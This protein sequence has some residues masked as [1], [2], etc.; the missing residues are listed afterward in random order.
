MSPDTHSKA[1]ASSLL[2]AFRPTIRHTAQVLPQDLIDLSECATEYFVQSEDY[3]IRSRFAVLSA[4][5]ELI[6]AAQASKKDRE[7]IAR[8]FFSKAFTNIAATDARVG[9]WLA[10][11]TTAARTEIARGECDLADI[12]LRVAVHIET[13]ARR[14]RELR[15]NAKEELRRAVACALMDVND[16]QTSRM[17][18]PGFAVIC[19]NGATALFA[20]RHTAVQFARASGV[21]YLLCPIAQHDIRQQTTPDEALLAADLDLADTAES[22]GG[23]GDKNLQ[24]NAPLLV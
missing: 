21:G 8:D 18:A 12:D 5:P 9:E 24:H 3:S 6:C 4:V 16:D 20:K 1:V 10:S 13:A 14:L 23:G 17:H 7:K 2:A 19:A 11:I 22:E 15:A